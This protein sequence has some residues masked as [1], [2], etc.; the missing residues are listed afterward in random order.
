[1]NV[2]K[3][4]INSAKKAWRGEEKL[5]KVFWLWGVLAGIATIF[6]VENFNYYI[7]NLFMVFVYF[8]FFLISLGRCAKNTDIE[9][10]KIQRTVQVFVFL[11]IIL[12]ALTIIALIVSLVIG[13]ILVC[14]GGDPNVMNKYFCY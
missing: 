1:M 14:S 3:A 4:V 11:L 12:G 6:L 7:F 13:W 10:D 5:W 2:V 8:P 9:N